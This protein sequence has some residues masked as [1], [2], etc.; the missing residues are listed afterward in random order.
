MKDPKKKGKTLTTIRKKKG[1]L[2]SVKG[3]TKAKPYKVT[4]NH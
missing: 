3:I 4:I 2:E 1:A